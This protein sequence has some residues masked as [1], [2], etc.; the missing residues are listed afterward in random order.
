MTFSPLAI[1]KK[2]GSWTIVVHDNG[3][4]GVAR[5][6]PPRSQQL[7]AGSVRPQPS[8]SPYFRLPRLGPVLTSVYPANPLRASLLPRS[9]PKWSPP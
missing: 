4:G 7:R 8:A 3:V 6:E 1:R 9:C 2:L 5:S